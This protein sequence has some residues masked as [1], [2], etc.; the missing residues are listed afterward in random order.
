MLLSKKVCHSIHITKLAVQ[1]TN[2]DTQGKISS[3]SLIDMRIA[4]A[5]KQHRKVQKK[6]T[7]LLEHSQLEKTYYI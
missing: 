4:H 1:K 2:T 3:V 6:K 7:L 5:N